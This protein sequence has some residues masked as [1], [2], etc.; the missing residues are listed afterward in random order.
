MIERLMR[1]PL[2]PQIQALCEK[3]DV[4]EPNDTSSDDSFV[5]HV[6]KLSKHLG[7]WERR[8]VT[9]ALNKNKRSR[10]LNRAMELVI[11]K[12][13]QEQPIRDGYRWTTLRNDNLRDMLEAHEEYVAKLNGAQ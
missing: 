7:F 9:R 1:L 13:T 6:E 3:I 12:E 11:G 10:V 2:A 8:C 4:Y 5:L